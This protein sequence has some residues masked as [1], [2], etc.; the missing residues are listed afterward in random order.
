VTDTPR[1]SWSPSRLRDRSAGDIGVGLYG[2]AWIN[3]KAMFDRKNRSKNSFVS[4]FITMPGKFPGK[5][6]LPI[7]SGFNKFK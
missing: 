1:S 6:F 3:L 2:D 4:N 5:H 7:T